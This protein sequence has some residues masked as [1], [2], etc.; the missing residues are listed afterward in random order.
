MA[1]DTRTPEE[2]A[3]DAERDGTLY[4]KPAEAPYTPAEYDTLI[5]VLKR[6]EEHFG[7]EEDGTTI[8]VSHNPEGWMEYTLDDDTELCVMDGRPAGTLV[9]GNTAYN[10]SNFTSLHQLIRLLDDPSVRRAVGYPVESPPAPASPAVQAE[11]FTCDD[12]LDEQRHGTELGTDY[13]ASEH[14]CLYVPDDASEELTLFA[15]GLD[16]DPKKVARDLPAL[17]A[18]LADPRVQAARAA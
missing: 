5:S 6:I 8:E 3:Y 11:R 2:R 10:L 1:I 7:L 17:T 9:W 14:V 12:D 4:T 16:L 18:L 15:F 13:R